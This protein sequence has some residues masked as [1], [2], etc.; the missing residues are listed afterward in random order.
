MPEVKWRKSDKKL[1]KRKDDQLEIAR[2]TKEFEDKGGKV[3]QIPM[4]LSSQ[5][6]KEREANEN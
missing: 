5:M 6:I 1:P 4:G 3:Q 2:L